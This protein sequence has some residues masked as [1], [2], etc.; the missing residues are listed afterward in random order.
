M[1]RCVFLTSVTAIFS[2]KSLQKLWDFQNL[3]SVDVSRNS[4]FGKLPSP[5]D[6]MLFLL[7]LDV[8][9]NNLSGK[10]PQEFAK[11]LALE[12]LDISLNPN[13]HESNEERGAILNL[14]TVD[15]KTFTQR[16]PDQ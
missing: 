14:V 12:V 8:S 10:I 2:E 7:N 9:P 6:N 4:L 13:M 16:N 11:L 5:T 3:I 15:F 1:N